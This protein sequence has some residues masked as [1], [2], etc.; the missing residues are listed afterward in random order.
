MKNKIILFIVLFTPFCYISNIFGRVKTFDR[1]PYLQLVTNKSGYIVFRTNEKIN[2]KIKLYLDLKKKNIAENKKISFKYKKFK[3]H[4]KE[5]T[6]TYH[7]YEFFINGLKSNKKYYYEIFDNDKNIYDLKNEAYIKTYPQSNEFKKLRFWVLGDSGTGTR[8]PPAVRDGMLYYVKK[9]KHDLDMIMHVGDMAYPNGTNQEFSNNFFNPYRKII[10]R[11]ACW[12]TLGNHE[13]RSSHSVTHA[14]T[15]F[16]SKNTGPYYDSYILPQKNE[17]GGF[18][19][20][21]EAYYSF[22]FGP[23]HFISLNSHNLNRKQSGYMAGWLHQDLKK[24]TNKKVKNNYKWLIAFWHHPPYTKGTHDSDKEKREIEMRENII[25]ILENYGVDLVFTGHSH[26]YERSMLIDKAY[27]TPTVANNRVLSDNDNYYKKSNGLKPH[28]GTVQV[29]VGNSGS[30]IAQ[31][32][33]HSPV[34]LKTIVKPGSVI[35]DI[36]NNKLTSVLIDPSGRILDKFEIIKNQ[37]INYDKP[38]SI[39]KIPVTGRGSI[40][41]IIPPKSKWELTIQK[42]NRNSNIGDKKNQLKNVF[43]PYHKKYPIQKKLN[44]EKKLKSK[45]LK[46]EENLIIK[47]DFYIPENYPLD[48]MVLGI[49]CLNAYVCYINGKE[50]DRGGFTIDKK[51]GKEIIYNNSFSWKY[52]D[53][54]L[55]HQYIPLEK[56]SN[57]FKFGKNSIEI[58]VFKHPKHKKN[59]RYLTIDACLLANI[60]N[61]ISQKS[62]FKQDIKQENNKWFISSHNN[63]SSGKPIDVNKSDFNWK[64]STPPFGFGYN[65]KTD[66]SYIWSKQDNILAYKK[67]SIKNK[68]ELKKLALAIRFD[69][70]ITV[71]INGVNIINRNMVFNN[72]EKKYI[73]FPRNVGDDGFTI[74]PIYLILKDQKKENIINFKKIN[75]ILIKCYNNNIK[76]K[77][78]LLDP[79]LIYLK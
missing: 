22:D 31:L 41:E 47:R 23:I 37:K 1:K 73:L 72:K 59:N 34:M 2:P 55:T 38:I 58:K 16:F 57:K 49:N 43:L 7:Q 65:V 36:E 25:P 20:R 45:L 74:I 56:H 68:S 53:V 5:V 10:N 64:E 51:T 11:V 35:V 77:D 76:S 63:D 18:P 6:N 33:G 14:F 61:F 78:F 12:P 19:S 9:T 28:E 62:K 21:T 26:I 71:N 67:F 66:M 27:E 24:I 70:S 79:L 8:V 32:F 29:V 69:D 60:P 54:F 52:Y 44:S 39:P 75:T 42:N 40:V 3:Y 48:R 30:Y 13:G 46:K 15:N 17:L 50:V 4:E